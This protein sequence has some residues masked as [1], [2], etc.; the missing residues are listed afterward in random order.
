MIINIL[1]NTQLFLIASIILAFIYP[2]WGNF[3]KDYITIILFVM[4]FIPFLRLKI[5]SF[6]RNIKF[7]LKMVVVS[8]VFYF[9]ISVLL[10]Y[11][12][13]EPSY[14]VSIIVLA[15]M[16]PAVSNVSMASLVGV[17]MDKTVFSEVLLYVASLFLTPFIIWYFYGESVSVFS[18]VKV[19]FI[20]IV[21]PFL[22]SRPFYNKIKWDLKEVLN[23]AIGLGVY[24]AV[25]L[26]VNKLL[27]DWYG[28]IPLFIVLTILRCGS[29][30]IIYM[31]T[32]L[33]KL[34]KSQA[35]PYFLFGT[36]KNA[37]LALGFCLLLFDPLTALPFAVMAIINSF[38]TIWY[39]WLF[40]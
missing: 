24:I 9:I 35:V 10:T 18:I 19:L 29:G 8:Y 4:M 27:T 15:A 22:F 38:F 5:P 37:N 36:S 1:R 32:K 7:G 12:L 25:S 21:L 26:N 2:D 23:I 17:K 31:Y 20:L 30:A 34:P 3:L 40:K 13:K 11:F 28:L 39:L 6:D 16:P 14:A 33:R